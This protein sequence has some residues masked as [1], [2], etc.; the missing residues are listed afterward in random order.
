MRHVAAL[1][2]LVASLHCAPLALAAIVAACPAPAPAAAD[3]ITWLTM[4]FPPFYIHDGKDRGQ[5]IADGVTH[6]CSATLRGYAHREELAEPATIMTRLKAGD[7]VCSA[8]Y[9]RTAERERVLEYSLPDLILPPNGITVRRD[10]G[11]RGSP[12]ARPARCRSPS[13]SPTA[14]SS[15]RWRWGV[16]RPGARRPARAHQGEPARL[17]AP[18]RGHLPSLFDMLLKGSVD[19]L[20]GY[21]YEAL[22]LARER[23]VEGQVVTLPLAELPDY[24]LRTW[25]ARDALGPRRGGRG[26][27]RAAAR[28]AAA[29]VPAGHRALARRGLQAEFR[30]QYEAKFLAARRALAGAPTALDALDLPQVHEVVGGVEL[31]HVRHALVAALVVHADALAGPPAWRRASGAGWRR[32]WRANSASESARLASR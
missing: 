31:E 9:I 21:P 22:Y 26:Q 10:D 19:Y 14:S 6:C 8:A 3:E 7:H 15:W 28:A 4:E 18:R 5:G 32:G 17:L 1:R 12:A 2:T 30:R 24:T 11:A 23:G 27:P 29:R 25:S 20:V 16:R 13:C